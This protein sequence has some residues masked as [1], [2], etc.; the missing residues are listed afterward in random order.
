M[1]WNFIFSVSILSF[2]LNFKHNYLYLFVNNSV[3]I[4][5]KSTGSKKITGFLFLMEASSNPLV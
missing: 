3:K 1:H 5:N 2:L 4:S